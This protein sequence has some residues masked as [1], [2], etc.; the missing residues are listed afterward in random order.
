MPNAAQREELQQ[1]WLL[2][3]AQEARTKSGT[4]MGKGASSDAVDSDSTIVSCPSP[5]IGLAVLC[6]DTGD[7]SLAE[8]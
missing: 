2:Y 6:H 8:P 3:L 7:A 5:T 1:Q 4:E